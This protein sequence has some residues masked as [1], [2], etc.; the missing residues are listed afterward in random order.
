M[1]STRSNRRP[2]LAP[3]NPST[4]KP[5]VL[6]KPTFVDECCLSPDS[7]PDDC[8]RS[9][10][11]PI[12]RTPLTHHRVLTLRRP[13]QCRG[14]QDDIEEIVCF[15]N[16]IS[17]C[18]ARVYQAIWVVAASIFHG[19]IAT[20]QWLAVVAFVV[21][22]IMS[23]SFSSTRSDHGGGF[24]GPI[25][26]QLTST[27]IA[28]GHAKADPSPHTRT[29][30][31]AVL[32]FLSDQIGHAHNLLTVVGGLG[33]DAFF[34]Y[35]Q[36]NV[37]RFLSRTRS[38]SISGS[39]KT[40]VNL[41][42][43]FRG[44]DSTLI[45]SLSP[46]GFIGRTISHAL[47][48]VTYHSKRTQTAFLIRRSTV[49][50]SRLDS[51][52]LLT[53]SNLLL[54]FS[55]ILSQT[56]SII[57]DVEAIHRQ[58]SHNLPEGLASLQSHKA[59]TSRRSIWAVFTGQRVDSRAVK[60]ESVQAFMAGLETVIANLRQLKAY[61]EWITNQLQSQR[62]LL[63][64]DSIVTSHTEQSCSSALRELLDRANRASRKLS[65]CCRCPDSKDFPAAPTQME[66]NIPG[67]RTLQTAI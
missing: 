3:L 58:L 54:E 41:T 34:G 29:S 50:E 18:V 8:P 39:S 5:Q 30:E 44:L 13:T 66:F 40:T 20:V 67:S 31:A 37:Q 63:P 42:V 4:L 56:E 59:A 46:H 48:E 22:V 19:T 61:L 9:V 36:T 38:D 1:T 55:S 43:D 60:E 24:I 11:V 45:Q 27:A 16:R 7:P 64:S 21:E 17:W 62:S 47:D 49:R 65:S 14:E 6:T 10:L 52:F 2:P 33:D 15:L 28:T 32:N 12:Y 51:V 23:M 57:P 35:H 53:A 25:V 26:E